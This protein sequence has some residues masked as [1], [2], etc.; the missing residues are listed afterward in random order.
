MLRRLP[1]MTNPK[2]RSLRRICDAGSLDA[3]LDLI[4]FGRYKDAAAELT[5]R[6]AT[7]EAS[8]LRLLLDTETDDAAGVVE[9]LAP[10]LERHLSNRERVLAL[11]IL[12]RAAYMRGH[13]DGL[14]HVRQAVR[15]AER[16]N[17]PKLLA[18]AQTR[19][20]RFVFHRVG[21][22]ASMPEL[23][24]LRR[25]AYAAAD[26]HTLA[27]FHC[28][29]SEIEMKRGKYGAAAKHLR[30]ADSLS[31]NTLDV[32]MVATVNRLIANAALQA[33]EPRIGLPAVRK[34]V[35]ILERE[36]A[37]FSLMAPLTTLADLDLMVGNLEE[38]ESASMRALALNTGD[39]GR[40][41]CLDTLVKV[42]LA[43]SDLPSAAA[44]VSSIDALAAFRP[45]DYYWLWH[46]PTRAR[47]LILDGRATEAWELLQNHR[48]GA[49]NASDHRLLARYVFGEV[50][51]LIATDQLEDAAK[52]LADGVAAL[53]TITLEDLIQV[54]VLA[55]SISPRSAEQFRTRARR[56]EQVGLMSEA[57]SSEYV[58][59]SDGVPDGS[60]LHESA[61]LL[62]VGLHPELLALEI[63]A[64]LTTTGCAD[65]LLVT[66]ENGRSN[67][68]S[69]SG[70]N[71]VPLVRSATNDGTTL[72]VMGRPELDVDSQ[73]TLMG[74]R[75]IARAAA[76]L[77]NS[78]RRERLEPSLWP[79]ML[80]EEAFG[81][82][83]AAA[84][85]KD[86]LE[87]T[88]RVASS[89][90]TVLITGESGTGKKLF[91][92]AMHDAS[93][94]SARPFIPF[95]C[96]AVS[97]EMLDSQL[98]GYRRGAFTGAHDHFPGVIRAASG[99]T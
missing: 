67:R 59:T 10:L 58:T 23:A 84:S 21:I 11:F 39:S 70:V 29:V 38:A 52:T 3:V 69:P 30:V 73:I 13:P 1:R 4:D 81:M 78:R 40:L 15:L 77:A 53:P 80:S 71:G 95:N 34:A 45:D 19:L 48:R 16:C 18:R 76:D 87:I 57:D 72:V 56:L 35:D 24:L 82:V 93:H 20:T 8:I 17:D 98:F 99:G 94:R 42:D 79:E 33:S 68:A 51:A 63:A 6:Q 89:T 88:R 50:E 44:R 47:Y 83:T 26:T 96:S 60:S 49:A 32:G 27:P 85:M 2:S 86:L 36:G 9:R 22:E 62:A 7:L 14:V 5:T 12:G 75:L 92:R 61:T 41:A 43:R 65:A 28:L 97:R 91:A 90:A 74:V 66:S 64:L 54:N 31:A 37:R 55:A 46:V 25:H